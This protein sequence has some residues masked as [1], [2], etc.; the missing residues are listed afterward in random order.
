MSVEATRI[1]CSVEGGIAHVELARPDKRNAM[2]HESFEQL[3]DMFRRLGRDPA[4]RVV[5]L[6]AR[7]KLFC[8]GLDLAYAASQFVPTRGD[9]RRGS[10]ATS[11]GC[12][13]RST[14][15]RRRGRR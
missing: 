11:A 3:G 8:A 4:V 14:R 10:C 15:S 13:R 1:A 6:S 9:G 2:D 5:V 12:R 7:G